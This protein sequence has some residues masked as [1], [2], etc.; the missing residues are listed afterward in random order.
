MLGKN[1]NKID[2][3]KCKHFQRRFQI[4]PGAV[5]QKALPKH[6]QLKRNYFLEKITLKQCFSTYV[7]KFWNKNFVNGLK[8]RK[9]LPDVPR[10]F[11]KAI[12]LSWKQL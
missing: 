11:I 10:K 5:V 2:A 9:E 7:S 3:S 4:I 12:L 8:G 6:I 1:W